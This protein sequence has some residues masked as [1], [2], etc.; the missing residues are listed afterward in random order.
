MKKSPL[1]LF[2]SQQLKRFFL[3]ALLILI[4]GCESKEIVTS[5]EVGADPESSALTSTDDK[6]GRA[7]C[8]ER[9]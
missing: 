6:I 2:I 8:R 3:S 5:E 4:V 9:V 1:A 7:S